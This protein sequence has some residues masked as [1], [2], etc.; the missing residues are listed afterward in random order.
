M[1]KKFSKVLS[2][3][4]FT[5]KNSNLTTLLSKIAVS[6]ELF[7]PLKPCFWCKYWRKGRRNQEVFF[8]QNYAFQNCNLLSTICNVGK[9]APLPKWNRMI[10]KNNWKKKKNPAEELN[11]RSNFTLKFI[12]RIYRRYLHVFTE[13]SNSL[14]T[15]I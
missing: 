13:S 7:F 3:L 10:K 6:Y 2:S 9:H 1:K 8:Y 12:L 15:I 4:Q 5:F 11:E 14:S